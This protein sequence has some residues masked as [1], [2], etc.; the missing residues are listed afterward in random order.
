MSTPRASRPSISS[1]STARSMT[2]PLPITGVHVGVRMPEG[3][4]WS[5]LLARAVLLD[6]DGVAG[7]VAA[8]ELHDVVDVA[9]HEVG[10]LALALIAP[11]GPHQHDC[12]H[13]CTFSRVDGGQR[14]GPSRALRTG[15]RTQ[16][17]Y[18][19]APGPQPERCRAAVAPRRIRPD[20]DVA[21]PP[22]AGLRR[23]SAGVG[24]DRSR[25]RRRRAGTS[26]APR[27]W[28]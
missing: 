27:A 9:A 3:S 21:G 11:L 26:S 5:V 25:P 1:N 23:V 28:P 22:L 17:G 7:V 16:E 10:G 14:T 2:T 18:C 20:V 12:R 19:L 15:A 13:L 24:R 4:R 6:D 8:V